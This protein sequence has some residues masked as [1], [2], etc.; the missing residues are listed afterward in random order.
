MRTVMLNILSK[1]IC[2]YTIDEARFLRQPVNLL[3]FYLG[4]EYHRDQRQ[5]LKIRELENG[6]K[7]KQVYKKL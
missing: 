3:T 1:L 7:Y 5:L 4:S 6:F 2:M